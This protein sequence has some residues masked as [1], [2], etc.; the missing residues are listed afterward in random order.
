MATLGSSP[1]PEGGHFSREKAAILK[2][3]PRGKDG[4][5]LAPNGQRSKLTED[6][7]ATVRTKN[8]KQW[9]G[10]W[11]AVAEDAAWKQRVADYFTNPQQRQVI[12]VGRVPEVLR[13][14]GVSDARMVMPPSVIGK[15]TGGKHSLTREMVEQVPAALRD[16]IFV[17][18]SATERDAVTVLTEIQ[19][20]GRNVLAAIHLDRGA[21]NKPANVIVSLYDKS[22]MAIQGWIRDGLLRY[23]HQQKARSYFLSARLQLP[24][25]GSKAGNGTLLTE[26][27][28]VNRAVNPETVSKVVDENGEPRVVFHGTASEF[29]T[30]DKNA[31]KLY[32]D[33][34][35]GF[36]FE[37]SETFAKDYADSAEVMLYQSGRNRNAKGRVMSAFLD[38]K[39]PAEEDFSGEYDTPAEWIDEHFN[40]RHADDLKSRGHDGAVFSS[41]GETVIVAF[42]PNQIKSATGNNGAF[43]R[44]NPS[45]LGSSPSPESSAVQEALAKMPPLFRKVFED[46]EAGDSPAVVMKRHGITE[47]A[48]TNILNQVRSRLATSTA[49]A[50]PAGLQPVMEGDQFKGGRPDYALSTNPTV[51][52]VDQTRNESGV[53]DVRGCFHAQRGSQPLRSSFSIHSDAFFMCCL[54]DAPSAGANGTG[55]PFGI[56]AFTRWT[57]ET[58]LPVILAVLRIDWP[59]R[60]CFTTSLCVARKSLGDIVEP[61]GRPSFLPSRR[62][63]ARPELIRSTKVSRSLRA[64]S[65]NNENMIEAAGFRLPLE[66]RVSILWACQ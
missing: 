48:V 66:R 10:D 7:W 16:P 55:L 32:W 38:I 24:R 59:A 9:F 40:G 14:V 19:H 15:V 37:T 49:A 35:H 8:F 12:E 39:N 21:P 20:E 5:P 63:L 54:K 57:V 33:D 30:F 23:A 17:F 58:L 64:I 51:A 43:S 34:E 53:P 28:V 25:E 50:S 29:D 42:E 6:Q 31:A 18:D 13:A 45:T 62:A 61:A 2:T 27:D 3:A 60:S 46:I 56:T 22:P 36:F 44:E 11:E 65:A 4:H 41:N 1:A 26:A 52:A 47:R